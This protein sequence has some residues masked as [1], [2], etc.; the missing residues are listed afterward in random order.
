MDIIPIMSDNVSR[1][2]LHIQYKVS[3]RKKISFLYEAK[4]PGKSISDMHSKAISLN[5][6]NVALHILGDT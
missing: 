5:R 2:H 4:K 1:K 3:V 6:L